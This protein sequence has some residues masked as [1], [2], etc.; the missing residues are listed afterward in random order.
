[1]MHNFKQEGRQS[2][3]LFMLSEDQAMTKATVRKHFFSFFARSA[4]SLTGR[5]SFRIVISVWT[6]CAA[7]VMSEDCS[8]DSSPIQIGTVTNELRSALNLVRKDGSTTDAIFLEIL[9]DVQFLERPLDH[10]VYFASVSRSFTRFQIGQLVYFSGSNSI[11]MESLNSKLIH[12]SSLGV[13]VA[14][15]SIGVS[16]SLN[17]MRGCR[18]AILVDTSGKVS[19]LKL[20]ALRPPIVLQ[21][22]RK[23]GGSPLMGQRDSSYFAIGQSIK[24]MKFIQIIPEGGSSELQCP[25]LAVLIRAG[26]T[27]C[28]VEAVL[29]E[30]STGMKRDG[31]SHN[32]KIVCFVDSDVSSSEVSEV[33]DKY[34]L[35]IATFRVDRNRANDSP[36]L[37]SFENSPMII[38]WDYN[39]FI[40]EVYDRGNLGQ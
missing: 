40:T 5:V 7:V 33:L 4:L 6:S 31:T 28:Q 10:L 13:L 39:G 20:D 2:A 15:D 37:N 29:S 24:G 22:A 16:K 3:P 38:R 21:L 11:N 30:L 23:Y 32:Q 35:K 34:E 1:M 9:S 26:C 14:I 19:Y 25:G 12:T 27:K 8:R 17:L 36:R 18:A